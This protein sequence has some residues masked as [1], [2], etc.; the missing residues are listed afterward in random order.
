MAAAMPAETLTIAVAGR[1]EDAAR[2]TRALRGCDG[3]SAELVTLSTPDDLLHTLA[4][5]HIG[6]IAFAGNLDDLAGAVKRALMANRHVFVFGPSAIA[7]KHLLA[8]DALARRRGRVLLFDTEGF[9]DERTAFVRKMTTGPRALWRPRYLR[10]LRTGGSGSSLEALA[11]ADV[12]CAMSLLGGVPARVAAIA[13]RLD[14]ESGSAEVAMVTLMFD[15]G[16][17]A[18]IDVS[19]I[20]QE[21]RHEITLACDG[22]TVVLDAFNARSPLRIEANARQRGSQLRGEQSGAWAETVTERPLDLVADRV[23]RAAAAFVAAARARDVT[24]S[25]ARTLADAT[26]VW[27][28]AR[29]SMTNG[30]APVEVD[31][32][33]TERPRLKLIVGGGQVDA[34][35]SAPELTMIS[36]RAAPAPEFEPDPEPLRTA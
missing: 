28:R 19:L 36:G 31:P 11:I 32:V 29:T 14:D 25:N 22:R 23:G 13:P 8:L 16:P 27:E 5:E 6:A 34:S 30:G 17:A 26:R 24:A 18:R 4:R 1:G 33:R 15:G 7:S 12:A 2:W 20:E 35:S 3:A 21:P 10:S 9:G